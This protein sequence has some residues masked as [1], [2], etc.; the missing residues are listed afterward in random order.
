MPRRVKFR[1]QF[2]DRSSLEGASGRGTKIAFGE[3]GLKVMESVWL[4]S[5]QIEAARRTISNYSKRGGRTWIR[6]FPHKPVSKK[7]IETRMGSGKAPVDHYVAV[8]NAGK[9]VF[10][11][12]G[13]SREIAVEALRRAAHK[14]PA[15]MRFVEKNA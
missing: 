13:V 3:F 5:R 14:L 7:A 4:T 15:K 12:S 6:V 1:R 9:V 2:R 10:E 11:M 8:V